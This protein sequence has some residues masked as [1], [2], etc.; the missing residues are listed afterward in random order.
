MG[1]QKREMLKKFRHDRDIA[2]ISIFDYRLWN[3]L[4][5]NEKNEFS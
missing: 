5:R 1:Y 2:K 4:F 3:F